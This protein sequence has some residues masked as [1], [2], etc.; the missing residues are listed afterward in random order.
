MVIKEI[1]GDWK[2]FIDLPAI[3]DIEIIER[4][5]KVEIPSDISY[6]GQQYKFMEPLS[7]DV[8]GYWSRPAFY[9]ELSVSSSV[10]VPCSRCLDPAVVAINGKFS[11]LYGLS[12]G[13]DLSEHI[14][15]HGDDSFVPV[16]SWGTYLNITPQ[17]WDSLILSLPGNVLC[18]SDCK[19]LCPMCGANLNRETCD[20][21]TEEVDP[22]MEILKTI[23]QDD[24]GQ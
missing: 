12:E 20:C 23:E 2:F 24:R 11:Y 5:W 21:S 17:V 10:E 14:E 6:L 7:V 22:R 18:S 4:S 1:P 16:S 8:R 13:N 15:G 9:V 3:D 19:G